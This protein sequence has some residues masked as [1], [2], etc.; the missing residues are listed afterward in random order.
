M[1][2]TFHHRFA[3][4]VEAVEDVMCDP[5]FYK[6]LGE[7]PDIGPPEVLDVH[8]QGRRVA[9]K[10]RFTFTGYMEPV[11]QKVLRGQTPSWVQIVEIDRERNTADLRIDPD[12][13]GSV[14]RCTGRYELLAEDG[15]TLRNLN[16]EFSVRI[17]LLGGR[18]E[19]AIGPGI[20][21]RLDLESGILR[22][23]LASVT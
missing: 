3:A 2:F 8:E 23:R 13:A 14:V 19:K 20:V 4:S 7:L 12:V 17:P 16:G 5:E 9:V 18:A 22:K 6:S 15:G 10:V 1:L 11:A 21:R